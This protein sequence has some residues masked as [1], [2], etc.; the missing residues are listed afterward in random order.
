VNEIEVETKRLWSFD[1]MV[2]F[3]V[4][5][6]SSLRMITFAGDIGRVLFLKD[7]LSDDGGFVGD[8]GAHIMQGAGMRQ[9]A[10]MLLFV[11]FSPLRNPAWRSEAQ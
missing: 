1:A 6:D 3:E 9:H 10:A 2:V 8:R 11:L 5:I 4:T 7:D